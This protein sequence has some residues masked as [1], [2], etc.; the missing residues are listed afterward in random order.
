MPFRDSGLK[1]IASRIGGDMTRTDFIDKMVSKQQ[2]LISSYI[3]SKLEK[4]S[5]DKFGYVNIEKLKNEII[6]PQTAEA[7]EKAIERAKAGEDFGPR[8]PKELEE[9][10]DVTTKQLEELGRKIKALGPRD[11]GKASQE[12]E[13]IKVK[14]EIIKEVEDDMPGKK[15]IKFQ[16][17]KEGQFEE[18][19]NPDAVDSMGKFKYTELEKKKI[20]AR[21]L[22]V[23]KAAMSAFEDRPELS[24]K[25][26]DP[27]VIRE[28]IEKY[29][30][31][32]RE[33]KILEKLATAKRGELALIKKAELLETLGGR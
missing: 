1:L 14:L 3:E 17:K 13:D 27:D 33:R 5:I 10:K 22:K 20:K 30:T 16:S 31:T 9:V 28:E 6:K 26:D 21:N 24:G 25:F 11:I 18:L 29:L 2:N 19:K 12:L 4:A 23:T 8:V 32:A 7:V 15:L